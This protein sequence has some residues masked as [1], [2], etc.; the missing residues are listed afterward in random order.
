[1]AAAL[2]SRK[3]DAEAKQKKLMQMEEYWSKV[4]NQAKMR[5]E[6]K[7]K[8]KVKEPKPKKKVEMEDVKATKGKAK[9]EKKGEETAMYKRQEKLLATP[10]NSPKPVNKENYDIECLSEEDSTDDEEYPKKAGASVGSSSGPLH[11]T[12]R[13]VIRCTSHLRS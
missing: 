5:K 12:S 1:M 6:Q 7:T 8:P 4:A 2:V 9:E 10:N 13:R 3:K 11:S